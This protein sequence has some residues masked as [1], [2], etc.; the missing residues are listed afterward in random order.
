[1][2]TAHHQ[3][4]ANLGQARDLVGLSVAI[5]A[6]TTA[7]LDTSDLL[8]SALVASVSSL[9][10][11]VHEVVRIL[12]IETALGHRAPTD[13]F[14][15][16]LIS[17]DAALRASH[18]ASPHQWMD[19]EVRRQHGHLSFQHPDKIADAIRLVWDQPMWPTVGAAIGT[20]TTTLKQEL[21]LIVARR[22]QIAHEA[23]RDPTPPHHRWPILRTDVDH[24]ISLIESVVRA[25]DALL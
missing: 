8:R 17:A 1:M 12:M 13:A 23:D 16:F 5:D 19:E 14:G 20:D 11:Y 22:N 2:T 7:A 15:R 3:F 25:L 9:D 10:H 6:T 21:Q 18:G 24:A 4:E